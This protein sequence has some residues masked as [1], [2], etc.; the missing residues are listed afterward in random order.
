ML[1]KGG[2]AVRLSMNPEQFRRY[3][4]QMIDWFMYNQFNHD[5]SFFDF[6]TN[7]DQTS[8]VAIANI[9]YMIQKAK[10][11]AS[12]SSYDKCSKLMRL[13]KRLRPFV[14]VG[15][16]QKNLIEFDKDGYPT[17]YFK[18]NYNYG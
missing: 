8:N 10:A 1:D 14:S 5:N 7:F 13:Y 2:N 4:A 11:R 6:F 9:V 16:W 3:R 18:S 17:G 15:N 12:K